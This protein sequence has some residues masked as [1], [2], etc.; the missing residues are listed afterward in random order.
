MS[1]SWRNDAL[2]C[3]HGQQLVKILDDMREGWMTDAAHDEF[4]DGMLKQVGITMQQL[5]DEI[6]AG[7]DNGYSPE[8]QVQIVR[9]VLS[10]VSAPAVPAKE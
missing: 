6:Q 8:S 4:V 2:Q 5:D 10:F 3:R 7:V 9:L 1:M